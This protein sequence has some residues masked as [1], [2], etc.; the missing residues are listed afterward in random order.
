[1]A[2]PTERLSPA[3]GESHN[4]VGV[5][6]VAERMGNHVVGHHPAVPGV[7]ETAQAGDATRRLEDSLQCIHD[8]NPA[9]CIQALFLFSYNG[10]IDWE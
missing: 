3:S 1:M 8:D 6:A 4:M 5:E 2:G 9:V 10:F 7:G